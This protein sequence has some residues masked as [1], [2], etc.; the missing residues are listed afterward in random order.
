MIYLTQRI[1]KKTFNSIFYTRLN[2]HCV[3]YLIEGLFN[4]RRNLCDF[5]T[6]T[7]FCLCEMHQV[8]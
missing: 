3:D 4:Y 6:L 8:H 2:A 1:E 7:K 5:A